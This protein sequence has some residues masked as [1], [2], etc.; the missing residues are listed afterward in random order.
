MP[1]FDHP[2]QLFTVEYPEGWELCYQEDTG[3]AL[4]IWGE[5]P[6]ATALSLSPLAVASEAFDLRLSVV[7][8]A[9][10]LN[11]AVT[12]EQVATAAGEELEIGY[13]EGHRE[14]VPGLGS[15]CRFWVLRRGALALYSAQIGPGT[16]RPAER[17]VVDAI[18]Q[19]IRFPEV[20]PPTPGAFRERVLEVLAREYPRFRAD[21][22]EPFGIT[23]TM[24]DGGPAGTIG[25]ENLFRAALL[26]AD[27]AG[28]LIRQY[29]DQIIT[30]FDRVQQLEPF[31]TARTRLLPQL[32]SEQWVRDNPGGPHIAS[33]E[34]APGLLLCFALDEPER[35]VYVT[36]AMV[37]QWGVPLERVQGVAQDN[38][39]QRGGA[40][41]LEIGSE[42]GRPCALVLNTQDGYD[43]TRLA[44]PSVREA[45]AEALGDEYL[46]GLPNRDFLVAFSERSSELAAGI[47]RQ[48][49]Q[50]Y[51][52]MD[53]P[54]TA[55][56]YRVR[57]DS[58]EP[59]EL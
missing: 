41:L 28:A 52:Q 50:D 44:L 58:I 13:A 23:L 16:S 6:G 40:R 31:D 20:L 25:L 19:S 27:I 4:L 39:A 49:R 53:H 48:V 2:L 11:V 59:T 30:A 3:G 36:C 26:H 10:R 55:R 22:C 43:A 15:A 29:L 45:V 54:L 9:G 32:K 17:A 46:V 8:A 33:V 1:T 7:E 38:L 37:E 42:G 12:P 56:I 51:H 34:F 35:I 21:P 47:I 18:L 5:D 14:P 57:P 24:P